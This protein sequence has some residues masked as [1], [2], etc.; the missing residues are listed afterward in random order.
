[1]PGN[2]LRSPL[3]RAVVPVAAG[4]AFFAAL[5]GLTWLMAGWISGNPESVTNLGARTFEVG[6]VDRIAEQVAENGPILFPDL[7]SPDGTRSI[8]LDHRG[9]NPAVGW[10][11]FAAYP[12]DRPVTCL[13][14]QV[15]S[16][17]TFVDC[18]G[19]SLDIEALARPVDVRPIVENERT[20]Y[21][22][23]RPTSD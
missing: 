18:D 14:E 8:V 16:T 22:D 11:V 17:R 1:V 10:R 12:A 15:A 13:V 6:S 4:I 23:L 9:E 20:L 21:V 19:R 7:R 2:R 3:A 5:F